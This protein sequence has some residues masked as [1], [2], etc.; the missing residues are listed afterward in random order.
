MFKNGWT[1]ITD[2]ERSGCMS[3]STTE[4]NIKQTHAL[5]HINQLLAINDIAN[6]LQVIVLLMESS[7]T[8]SLCKVDSKTTQA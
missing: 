4:K 1:N 3:T 2:E 8:D 5:I 7:S 6:H